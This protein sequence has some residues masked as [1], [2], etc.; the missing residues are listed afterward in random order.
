MDVK[1]HFLQELKDQG[2][3]VIKFVPGDLNTAEILTKNTTGSIFER[4]IPNLVGIDEYMK[5]EPESQAKEGV[6]VRFS[7]VSGGT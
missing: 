4:H 2:L 5:T 3:L 7:R 1:N 6:R